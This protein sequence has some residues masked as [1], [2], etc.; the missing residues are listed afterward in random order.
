M[1]PLAED[2]AS[3]AGRPLVAVDL[4]ALPEYEFNDLR[5]EGHFF[6]PWHF[7][8]WLNSAMHL[9]AS[10]EVQ[11]V[12]RALFDI[13]QMQF[14]T[15]TLPDDDV[16]LSRLLRIDITHW[17]GLRGLEFGPLRNWFRVR[18]GD[19]V[20]LAHPVVCEVI[21]Q[22]LDRREERER[23]NDA[24]AVAMRLKRL[25]DGLRAL[26]AADAMVRDQ[27]LI[28]RMDKWLLEHVQG[29]RRVEAYERVLMV[30]VRE[31]WFEALR[32]V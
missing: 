24:K 31:R 4:A 6:V 1:P 30:A 13:A 10:Y 5:L 25:R 27:V 20:R 18:C 14:P 22:V 23:A 16:Q 9:C 29:Q 7:G 8:R 28:E 32:P 26:G 21:S 2:R 3:A 19:Q 17:R 15:G 12:A 11:G